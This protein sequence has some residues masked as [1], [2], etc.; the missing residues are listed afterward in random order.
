MWENVA[1]A[2]A[3][4]FVFAFFDGRTADFD[5]FM[6]GDRRAMFGKLDDVDVLWNLEHVL[7]CCSLLKKM[8]KL[9]GAGREGL[10]SAETHC[11]LAS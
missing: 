1:F 10:Y 5:C 11:P 8:D 3:F 9:F 6:D 7:I 4:A 2:F